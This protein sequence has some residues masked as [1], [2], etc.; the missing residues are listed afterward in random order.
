MVKSGNV[1]LKT[2]GNNLL[3]NMS[4]PVGYLPV[5]MIIGGATSILEDEFTRNVESSLKSPSGNT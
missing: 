2:F 1:S 4:K 3:R 5:N